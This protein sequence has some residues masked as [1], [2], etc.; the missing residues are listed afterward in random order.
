VG[1]GSAV[2]RTLTGGAARAGRGVEVV[3]GIGED[4]ERA[5]ARIVARTNAPVVVDLEVTG[6]ALVS[7]APRRLPD[8]FAGAPALIGVRVRAQGGELVVHG[9]TTSG[10]WEARVRVP[11]T[12][13]GEGSQAVVALFGRESV[14]EL[15][16][17][18]AAGSEARTI[19]ASIER[20]GLEFQIATRVTSWV[21]IDEEPS[22]DPRAPLKRVRM[23]HELPHGMSVEGL[24]LR[25][26]AAMP[27]QA[28]GYAGRAVM[29]RAVPPPAA[30][31]PARMPPP[32]QAPPPAAKARTVLSRI[33]DHLRELGGSDEEGERSMAAG[34]P[35]SRAPEGDAEP[36]TARTGVAERVLRGRVVAHADGTIV[37]EVLVDGFDLAWSPDTHAEIDW[38]DGSH[39]REAVDASRT[40]RAGLVRAGESLRVALR[41]LAG[42]AP[43]RIALA[44]GGER[45]VIEL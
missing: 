29:A 45:I 26:C 1:V 12:Q 24:G 37:I 28:M 15:E 9:R 43:K 14:E 25:A 4:P 41:S 6:S 20:I 35:Y 30:M 16:M 10:A 7:H 23:P 44:C 31:S 27:M 42:A 32:P 3:A 34:R 13:P 40:T 17:D 38:A 39:S 21:A 8:L 19:D 2:N 22:V 5:A 33:V 18:L 11:P 36:T